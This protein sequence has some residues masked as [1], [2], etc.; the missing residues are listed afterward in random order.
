M[1]PNMLFRM[2]LD[3]SIMPTMATLA[4]TVADCPDFGWQHVACTRSFV[5]WKRPQHL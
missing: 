5:V 3:L 4:I 1:C 2:D